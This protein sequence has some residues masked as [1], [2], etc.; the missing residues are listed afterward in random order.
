M[1]SSRRESRPCLLFRTVR[2]VHVCFSSRVYT[3]CRQIMDMG[4]MSRTR[5]NPLFAKRVVRTIHRFIITRPR[6]DSP[7][8]SST[9]A[10]EVLFTIFSSIPET[11]D[12]RA[13]CSEGNFRLFAGR[14]MFRSSRTPALPVS[15]QNETLAAVA[16][17]AF[18]F[19][20]SFCVPKDKKV[21]QRSE[22]KRK[23]FTS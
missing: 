11:L 12:R 16:H 19:L 21:K 4:P 22:T 10:L 9:V 23:N 6:G 5:C 7:T 18:F 15:M 13:R 14:Y 1:C 8:H 2:G 20:L 17:P 3:V